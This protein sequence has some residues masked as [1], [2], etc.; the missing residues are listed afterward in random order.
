VKGDPL[1]PAGPLFTPPGSEGLP[2]LTVLTLLVAAAG[3]VI[4]LWALLRGRLPH[5]WALASVLLTVAA[6]GFGAV[7]MVEKSK[8]V[9]FCGSCHVMAP[10]VRSLNEDDGSLASLHYVSGRVPTAEACYTCHSGYGIWGG[11]RAKRAGF[12]HMLHTVMGS[13]DLPL[14]LDGKFDI[15]SCLNCHARAPRFRAVEAHKPLDLQEALVSGELS[16]VGVCH[17]AAHPDS[18]LTG[19]VAH[20]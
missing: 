17:P 12:R 15:N 16:C 13:Y 7:F 2:W 11:A 1:T 14:A 8:S 9:S 10:I 18:A 20:R 6:Y 3:A 19:A 4:L 5:A